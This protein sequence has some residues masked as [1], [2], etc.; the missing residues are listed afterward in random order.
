MTTPETLTRTEPSRTSKTLSLSRLWT[1]SASSAT[2]DDA[3]A[4]DSLGDA[5]PNA[6][7]TEKELP[8]PIPDEPHLFA[9][10]KT[11]FLTYRPV[12]NYVRAAVWLASTILSYLTTWSTKLHLH[13]H[14][15]LRSAWSWLL[16]PLLAVAQGKLYSSH[17]GSRSVLKFLIQTCAWA[18]V[19][20]TLLQEIYYAPS[21]LTIDTLLKQYWLPSPLSRYQSVLLKT[22][23]SPTVEGE[24]EDENSSSLSSL[25][26]HHLVLRNAPSKT[27]SA[28]F[29]SGCNITAVYVNHGFGTSSLS[30]LPAFAP[31]ARRLGAP[32]VMGHDA[33]GF[34]FT[35]RPTKTASSLLAYTSQASARIG[36]QL[37]RE[38][39]QSSL[40]SI[41][42]VTRSSAP[43]PP[44]LLLMGHSMGAI[45][46]LHM[47]LDWQDETVAKRIVL[48][49][50]AFLSQRRG[51]GEETSHGLEQHPRQRRRRRHSPFRSLVNPTLQY[52]LRRLVGTPGFWRNGLQLAWGEPKRLSDTDVLRFQWPSIG[53]GWEV[54]LLDFSRA[55]F[56]YGATTNSLKELMARVLQLPNTTVDVIIASND[57][58]VEP[59]AVRN[60]LRDFPSVDILE[61]PR[62]GHDPFEEDTTVFVD[63]LE[64]LLRARSNQSM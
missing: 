46:T 7:T 58:V 9:V 61:L 56:Q 24:E 37:L 49:S 17:V 40:A 39:F 44:T 55:Q 31:L 26:V 21:R 30:W 57:R 2:A 6:A 33:V 50:P 36:N 22:I 28:S 47:A 53:K 15:P 3:A 62:L 29:A 14:L 41:T 45:T 20:T 34:G 35:E 38:Q 42:N 23:V 48:V 59:K 1:V 63:T 54:G 8:V 11:V 19:S 16:H 60:F 4:Q 32:V 5:L 27:E 51:R 18:L 10:P 43:L 12:P 64:E 13:H 52:V 25:G